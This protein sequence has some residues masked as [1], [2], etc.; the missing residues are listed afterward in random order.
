MGIFL[1]N[2]HAIII[3][4]D[5]KRVS[6]VGWR[7]TLIQP[8]FLGFAVFGDQDNLLKVVLVA[9]AIAGDGEI[10]DPD[11]V[12]ILDLGGDFLPVP[13]LVPFLALVGGQEVVVDP[14][15]AAK[16]VP[17]GSSFSVPESVGACVMPVIQA[18]VAS[19]F[20]DAWAAASHV[21][22]CTWTGASV[23]PIPGMACDEQSRST[24]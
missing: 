4:P 16:A 19:V 1:K 22:V 10:L 18:P 17:V 5:C 21:M 20:A 6:G 3:V 24:F 2:D 23:I 12:L 9:V 13:V 14:L 8:W 15:H 7:K 11:L